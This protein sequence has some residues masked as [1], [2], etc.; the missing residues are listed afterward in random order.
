MPLNCNSKSVINQ[1]FHSKKLGEGTQGQKHQIRQ[2]DRSSRKV[3]VLQGS[4]VI[5]SNGHRSQPEWEVVGKKEE[6][7]KS[8]P[9]NQQLGTSDYDCETAVLP[10]LVI[11]FGSLNRC[12]GLPGLVRALPSSSWTLTFKNIERCIPPPRGVKHRRE[13]GKKKRQRGGHS[14]SDLRDKECVR[15]AGVENWANQNVHSPFNW[16]ENGTELA[17]ASGSK[18]QSGCL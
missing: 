13:G 8:R 9:I 14:S 15:E 3:W 6:E 16:T 7:K 12:Q 18:N 17:F 10:S 1:S 4:L 2:R 5:F 11:V